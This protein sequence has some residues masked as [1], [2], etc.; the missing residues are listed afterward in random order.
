MGIIH[1][2]LKI[3]I[4][5]TLKQQEVLNKTLGSCRALYN[6]MLFERIQTYDNWKASGDDVRV[7]YEYEYKTEK[8]YKE[9]YEWL[10]DSV[11]SQALQQSRINLS[12]AYQNFFKSLKG[13]IAGAKIGFPKFKKKR[14]GSSYRTMMTNN[15]IQ[16]DFELR[17]VKLPKAGWLNFTDQRTKIE[18]II[19]SATVSRSSTGKYFVSLLI[20][21][22]LILNGVEISDE[23]KAKTIGLDMSL[24]KLFVD[25][26]GNSPAYERL[27]RKYEPSLKK[28]QRKMSKKKKGSKNWYKALHKV[29]LIHEIITNKRKDF[30]HKLSTELIRNNEV[31]VVEHLSLKG[32]SQALNLGKSVMDLGYSEFVRQLSYK[33]LWNNKT[34]IQADKWF[35]SSKTCSICGFKNKDLQLSDRD[36]KCP[37]CGTDHD[38]D[39]NA[40]Q[41][42]KNYGLNNIGLGQ[43]KIKPVE[44]KTSETSL[45]GLSLDEEAGRSPVFSG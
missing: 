4:Y 37:N 22:E 33:S 8:Q 18:G 7:L 9:E 6:M 40:G 23:L 26:K 13:K 35:A 20:E 3:R 1:K 15:N 43:P 31:I 32:M 36:W 34:F 39:Q 44:S 10:K 45:L 19:K 29:N 21:Q 2:A 17:K 24:E 14:T 16:I 30:T 12:M 5:P 11:D 27:Y 38:R 28:A 42:L 41:N 25:D